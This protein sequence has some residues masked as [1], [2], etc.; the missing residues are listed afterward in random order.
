M[1]L[2]KTL[3]LVYVAIG[4]LLNYAVLRSVPKILSRYRIAEESRVVEKVVRKAKV[5]KK[6]QK[7]AQYRVKTFRSKVFRANFIQMML[8]LLVFMAAVGISYLISW[9]AMPKLVAMGAIPLVGACI[10]PPPLEIPLG[11]N[12]CSSSIV[13]IQFMIFLIFSPW[14]SATIRRILKTQ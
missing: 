3:V 13:W 10:A 1:S 5:S 7:I 8:P 11:L 9:I 4:V 14:Y 12:A 6:K 2:L